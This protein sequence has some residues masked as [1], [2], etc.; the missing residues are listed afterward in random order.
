MFLNLTSVGGN[1]E[2]QTKFLIALGLLE[3]DSVEEASLFSSSLESVRQSMNLEREPRGDEVHD[4][5]VHPYAASLDFILI[6][7]VGTWPPN[8]LLRML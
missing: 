1:T 6:S 3:S 2:S 4:C 5:N 8:P 7:V